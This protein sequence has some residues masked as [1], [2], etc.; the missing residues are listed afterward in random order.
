MTVF[1]VI[2]EDYEMT[3]IDG[4]FASQYMADQ[5]ARKTNEMRIKMVSARVE[6]HEVIE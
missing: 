1:V 3:Y 2:K 6:K 5:K 4:V